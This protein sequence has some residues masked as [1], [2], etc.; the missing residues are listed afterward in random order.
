MRPL[1]LTM[2][3]F[4]PY[5]GKTEL[6]MTLLGDRGLYLITGD[7][8]AGKTTIFDAITYAL[9]GEASGDNRQAD[10]FRSKYAEAETPTYVE[11]PIDYGGSTEYV[12]RNP[13][14][15]R[16]KSRGEG[17]TNEKAAAELHLP[18]GRILT[19]PREVN[20]TL[21]EILGVDRGQF[22]QIAMIAQ[23]DFLKLLLASTED[24]KKIFQKIFR[25]Q[26]YAR[27]Q[28]RLKEE[29][30]G[31]YK[32]YSDLKKSVA[33]YLTGLRCAPGHPREEEANRA[34]VG[35]LP[36][37]RTLSLLA[38]LTEEDRLSLQELENTA[39]ELDRQMEELTAL[40]TQAAHRS[41][42]AQSL[43][44]SGTRLENARIHLE[45][46][47]KELAAREEEQPH[48]EELA[49]QRTV[50]EGELQRYEELD[51][52]TREQAAQTRQLSQR[53]TESGEAQTLRE[54][55]TGELRK[56]EKE[57]AELSGADRLLAEETAA[58]EKTENAVTELN[59]LDRDC[60]EFAKAEARLRDAQEVYLDACAAWEQ[61]KHSF[62][63]KQKAYFDE[64]AGILARNLVPGMP[65]PVCGSR[66]HPVPAPLSEA[67][68][69]REE[70]DR[71]KAALNRAE[72]AMSAAGTEAASRKAICAE[73]Q[74][75][76]Q[77]K[78]RQ[79][80]S[81][82]DLED[83]PAALEEA[84]KKLT[85]KAA[86]QDEQIRLRKAQTERKAA[87]DRM[88]PEKQ[89][90][91]EALQERIGTLAREVAAMTAKNEAMSAQIAARKADL[92]FP[93]RRTAE[94]ALHALTLQWK[95]SEAALSSA[96]A[97]FAQRDKE[98]SGLSAAVLELRRQLE[99]CPQ[100]DAADAQS[101]K[102]ALTARRTA[103]TEIGRSTHLRLE[104]NRELALKLTAQARQ[105]EETEER[106]GWVNTLAN[107][108]NGSLSGR[109][110]I[111]L[112]TYIQTTCFDR[113]IRRAN[114]RLMVMS[115][116][117]YQLKRRREAENNRSQSGLDLDVI[118]HYN[119]TERSVKSLSGGE[120]VKA[121]LS[122]ALGLSDEIQQSAG[123]IRLDAMFVDEGFGSLDEESLGQAIR[124]LLELAE[125]SRLVGIIS[126]VGELKQRIDKQVV[127][128]KDRTGGSRIQIVTE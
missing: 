55:L 108:A 29:A 75:A 12:R 124:A 93:D 1:K 69:T 71:S 97:A 22:T 62:E 101:K 66:E 121:S 78:A 28:Q 119:G 88:I 48:R 59:R 2:S 106:Y 91:A 39:R 79:A 82:P 107:T 80:L 33:Q 53:N 99:D 109:E 26:A 74:S 31:L 94:E 112:E 3:A 127:V 96:R 34:R 9:Y 86:V 45:E 83:L 18:D 76:L 38:D 120:S 25:T 36:M 113:I 64:Q 110:K 15:T 103:L 118:D 54:E 84:K 51:R 24:R 117:Q 52:M 102:D 81:V 126:H 92:R 37:E 87:L 128:T 100:V 70:L 98:V 4:G 105:L 16:P 7:T 23:G 44:D 60:R 19:R 89:S 115:G 42:L 13:E 43:Q 104:A 67:A 85:R 21:V 114:A 95:Q 111:M 77:Q 65:C 63:K 20:Q 47:R 73:K 14:Y 57:R 123:G 40:L 32:N 49:R 50:V 61:A 30:I 17:F 90:Q 58:R 56:L 68:P 122:L 116:G 5:A 11:L 35:E 27:L 72:A 41:R 125:G 8:G 10:M 46:A 6:D